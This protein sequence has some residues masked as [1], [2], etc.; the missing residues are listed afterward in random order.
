MSLDYVYE[1]QPQ[2]SSRVGRSSIANY[3]NSIGWRGI[4]QRKV[5]LE[6]ALRLLIENTHAAERRV[7]ILDIAAGGGRYVLETMKALAEHSDERRAARL[8]SRR[9]SM[10]LGR[11]PTSLA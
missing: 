2:G 10:R 7:Q 4:R 9:M 11:S 5:N 1:N 3:L 6:A 8:Q